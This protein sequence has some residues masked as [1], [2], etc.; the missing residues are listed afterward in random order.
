MLWRSGLII[1]WVNLPEVTL[2]TEWLPWGS[3]ST[4]VWLMPSFCNVRHL[5]YML[6]DNHIYIWVY[7]VGLLDLWQV[8]YSFYLNKKEYFLVANISV[9]ITIS[10]LPLPDY[11]SQ[12]GEWLQETYL[13]LPGKLSWVEVSHSFWGGCQDRK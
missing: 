4:Y 13:I 10:Y 6:C 8:S 2:M 12:F 11:R 9:S 3:V 1:L 7:G 5:E